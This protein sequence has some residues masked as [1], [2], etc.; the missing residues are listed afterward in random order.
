[1]TYYLKVPHVEPN[2]VCENASAHCKILTEQEGNHSA[3]RYYVHN[4][5]AAKCIGNNFNT[6]NSSMH[7]KNIS[8][9]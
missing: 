6:F 7:A 1:M 9:T 5:Y 4:T 8:I 2:I 3:Q